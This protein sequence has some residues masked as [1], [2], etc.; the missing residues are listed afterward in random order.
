MACDMARWGELDRDA[1]AAAVIEDERDL[2]S[3]AVADGVCRRHITYQ[4]QRRSYCIWTTILNLSRR[5]CWNDREDD[6]LR[7]G[8]RASWARRAA[9]RRARLPDA[10]HMINH[11]RMRQC[12]E[13]LNHRTRCRPWREGSRALGLLSRPQM[14][15]PSWSTT[16]LQ[17][18][19]ARSTLAA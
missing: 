11:S 13:D 14:T 8:V 7:Q 3:S 15:G 10:V 4:T 19:G 9:Q 5:D 6:R 12:C 2:R 1:A 16:P 17:R 18:R